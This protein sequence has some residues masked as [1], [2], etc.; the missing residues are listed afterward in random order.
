MKYQV[1]ISCPHL[2]KTIELYRDKLTA[3]GIELEVPSMVQQLSEDELLGIIDR[4]DGVI[5]G[6]DHFSSKV[7]E[8]ATNLKI[9]AKWGIGV[10]AIDLEAAKKLNIPVVNTPNVFADEVSDVAL[11]Y[12]ILLARQLHKLDRS[13]RDGGWLQVPGITLRGKTLGVIGVGSIGRGMVTRGRAVGMSLLGYDVMPIP[14]SYQQET[15]LKSVELNKLLQES[16]FMVLCCNM[17]DDNYHLF[18]DREFGLMK[19]GVY[20]VNVA[21]GPLIDEQ[22]LIAALD[23]GKVSGAALDVFE[24]EPL[25][26]ASRLREFDQCIFGTHNGSHS[27]DAVLKV[28]EIAINNLLE[29]LGVTPL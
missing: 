13:V 25:P 28:N 3:K 4:F 26:A 6:D 22:A 29:G 16:D 8:K 1:L 20:I 10:D 27:I 7:L 11:G 15:G 9:L 19:D 2:Q 14:E 18:G 12:M 5:A 24:V 23:S 21:R 17:T